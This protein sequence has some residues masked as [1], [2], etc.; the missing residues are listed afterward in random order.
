MPYDASING[1]SQL[2]VHHDAYCI[3]DE[4]LKEH[5]L[6]EVA[7]I[8]P[9]YPFR[10][11]LPLSEKGE[12]FVVQ[13]RHIVVGDSLRDEAGLDLDRAHLTGRKKPNF[14]RSGDVLFMAKGTRN[15]ATT[16]VTVPDTT[17]CTPNFYHLRI[18]SRASLL[19]PE[20]LAWQLNHWDA[21]RYF[22]ACS[23]GSVAPS[24]TKS[25]LGHLPIVIPA[26]KQ[27]KRIAN[28]ARAA[29]REEQLLSKLIDNRRRM[30]AAAGHQILHST[31]DLEERK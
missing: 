5:R 21:Q 13:F 4:P 7:E 2:D 20:F 18:R 9:G 10:G 24:V 16:V 30:V 26:L 19:E 15:F 23:Q 11:K 1:L 12:A 8:R 27:Q 31:N 22:A 3:S 14:L 17:V 25:Q 6:Q 29:I 28:L